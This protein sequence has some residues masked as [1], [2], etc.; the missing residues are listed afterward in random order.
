MHRAAIVARLSALFAAVGLVLTFGA[1]SASAQPILTSP[2]NGAT[3]PLN[4]SSIVFT[5]N[6]PAGAVGTE[7]ALSSSP[8]TDATGALATFDP[9][10]DGVTEGPSGTYAWHPLG[11]AAGTCYW[12][13]TSSA[14]SAPFTFLCGD[15]E[16]WRSGRFG[17]ETWVGAATYSPQ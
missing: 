4:A 15:N 10:F 6:I 11:Q 17:G 14:C 2:A 8:A 9:T 7:I 13:A 3:F 5:V 1:G 12:Q 16:V